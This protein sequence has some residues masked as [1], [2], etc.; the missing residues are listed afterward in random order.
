GLGLTLVFAVAD[1]LD[2]EV[3]RPSLLLMGA[4]IV[5][6]LLW[7]RFVLSKRPGGWAPRLPDRD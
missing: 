7:H 5:A 2:P 3:G 4:L 6:A 1:L